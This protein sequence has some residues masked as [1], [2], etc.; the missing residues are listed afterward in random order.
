M[1]QNVSFLSV[2]CSHS[3]QVVF[4]TETPSKSAAIKS[5]FELTDEELEV[6][7]DVAIELE[8]LPEQFDDL[9][10]SSFCSAIPERKI[11]N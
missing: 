11:S 2:V 3:R 4:N 1:S 8:E 6:F 10:L 7:S 9:L 5:G